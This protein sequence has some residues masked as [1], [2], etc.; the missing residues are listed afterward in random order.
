MAVHRPTLKKKNKPFK[1]RHASKGSLKLAS[2][3]R[4]ALEV[5]AKTCLGH[6][7]MSRIDR[8]NHLNQLKQVKQAAIQDRQKIFQGRHGVPRNVG[9]VA[10]TDDIDAESV[11]TLFNSLVEAEPVDSGVP[12]VVYVPRFKMRLRY[13]VPRYGQF[14][15]SLDLVRACD[16]VLF[17]FSATTETGDYAERLVRAICAQGVT[18]NVGIIANMPD[19]LPPKRKASVR[20]SLTSWYKYFFADCE[21]LYSLTPN[22]AHDATKVARILCQKVPKG[23]HWRDEHA[24]MVAEQIDLMD[25]K[26]V[27]KGY[28]R[29]RALN[30]D[31]FVFIQG[32]GDVPIDTLTEVRDKNEMDVEGCT[33]KSALD[34]DQI[35]DLVP[36]NIELAQYE[37]TQPENAGV[38][39]DDQIY[40][41]EMLF[42]EAES[43]PSA[44]KVIPKGWTEYQAAWLPDDYGKEDEDAFSDE[45]GELVDEVRARREAE[46]AKAA[47]AERDAQADEDMDD[48]SDVSDVEADLPGDNTI[49]RVRDDLQFPDE[50]EL[51]PTES[52]KA[53]FAA[54]RGVRDLS[55]CEWNPNEVDE[56]TPSEWPCLVRPRNL[57]AEHNY[58]LKTTNHGASPGAL[59]SVV[60]RLPEEISA[61]TVA[62]TLSQDIRRG[63]PVV[64]YVLSITEHKLAMLNMSINRDSESTEPI[65]SKAPLLCQIG[66]RRL[67]IRPLFSKPSTSHANGVY[68]LRRFLQPNESAIVSVLA[69]LTFDN[70][71]VTYFKLPEEGMDDGAPRYIGRGSVLDANAN[72]VIVKTAVLTGYPVSIHRRVVTVRY[73]FFNKEDVNWFKAV[74][75]KTRWGCAGTI[76]ESLGT[77]GLFKATFDKAI[78]AQ[79]VVSMA[80]Y[81]REWPRR[82]ELCTY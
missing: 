57:Q 2:K 18:S 48:E 62:Q 54:Y 52:G 30:P 55:T 25:G 17:V 37:P 58:T 4:L 42:D 29:G 16:F 75:L 13:L 5:S 7:S 14:F 73:M 32:V 22:E 11:I 56:K 21:C 23:V 34:A 24:Y 35:N 19:T 31:S 39:I 50:V 65:V 64:L 20:Q 8:R 69:P 78:R 80:L 70:V 77:H 45:E 71:P 60:L 51:E 41:N 63:A 26:L 1:S 72:R 82:A 59:V 46:K 67:V 66:P 53:R 27:A 76:K 33:W 28:V 61:A 38:R 15:E 9:V 81:R 47:E 36:D 74:P 12:G 44:P 40:V 68:R 79:D 6:S 3:G 49:T 10:L 43:A